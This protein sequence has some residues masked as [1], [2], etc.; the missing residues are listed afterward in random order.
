MMKCYVLI[1]LGVINMA[2]W[3]SPFQTLVKYYECNDGLCDCFL[4]LIQSRQQ[5]RG[6]AGDS[7]SWGC[8][9]FS[10][11]QHRMLWHCRVF[12]QP[13]CNSCFCLTA[14]SW[15]VRDPLEESS[16]KK[17]LSCWGL[18]T[19]KDTRTHATD[20]PRHSA[21]PGRVRA[22]AAPPA[23]GP[24]SCN[25]RIKAAAFGSRAEAAL[26]LS[27]PSRCSHR[28]FPN[29]TTACIPHLSPALQ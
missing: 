18:A 28:C 14:V 7:S 19:R 12:A 13:Q 26:V 15:V 9:V 17:D 21:S 20:P 4:L 5:S 29:P 25:N 10:Q 16:L 22:A 8:C 3:W 24:S 1:T 6:R 2:G 23:Q 27:S 11:G